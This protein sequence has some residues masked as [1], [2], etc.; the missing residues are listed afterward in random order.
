M[1]ARAGEII[2]LS[3]LAAHGQ[4]Q[5]LVRI[6]QAAE[7]HDQELKVTAAVA[8]VAGDRQTDGVFPL[9]SILE[10]VSIRSLQAI[11][12]HLLISLRKQDE[13]GEAWRRRL[14]IRTP[15]MNNPILSLSGGNQQKALFARALASDAEIIVMD[16]PMRGVDIA[17][18][19][20]VYDIIREEAGKG[21][22][23]VWY[24]TEIEELE[25]C[26]RVYVLR[27]GEIVAALRHDEISEQNIIRSSFGEAA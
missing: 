13:I 12:S 18:K 21:R 5:L 8:V 24:T 23:F 7:R 10:N 27:N 1:D 20:E 4:S 6:F 19:L 14:G 2:G 15:D 25:N 17:T 26:D 16:D 22:T 11:T 9:W 3:G